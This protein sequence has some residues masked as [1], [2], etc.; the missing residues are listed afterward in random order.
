[1]GYDELGS[2]SNSP[3]T[4]RRQSD[5]FFLGGC[6]NSEL[7]D[8]YNIGS[9]VFV[10]CSTTAHS[11]LS[12]FFFFF[13]KFDW[14]VIRSSYLSYIHEYIKAADGCR[15]TGH[16]L[17]HHPSSLSLLSSSAVSIILAPFCVFGLFVLVCCLQHYSKKKAGS[18]HSFR[19][20]HWDCGLE[21]YDETSREGGQEW[22]WCQ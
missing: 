22:S 16:Q 19:L 17:S 6:D 12:L 11:N 15:V 8:M 14:P 7:I 1:M 2:R 21:K 9:I 20:C 5:L 3:P 13:R 4:I 18:L 10:C